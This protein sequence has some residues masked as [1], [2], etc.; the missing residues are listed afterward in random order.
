[1]DRQKRHAIKVPI[2][3]PS[4]QAGTTVDLGERGLGFVGS[5]C[6]RPGEQLKIRVML[7]AALP[8]TIRAQIVWCKQTSTD[9][10]RAYRCGARLSAIGL[11]ESL[12]L[13]DYLAGVEHPAA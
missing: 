7:P 4:Q 9:P 3:L 8:L 10:G 11:H 5:R 12:F 1:M 2:L 6:Y 13:K